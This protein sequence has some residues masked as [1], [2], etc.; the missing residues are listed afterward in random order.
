MVTRILDTELVNG[1]I[2]IE[3]VN[4]FH[5]HDYIYFWDGKFLSIFSR[6]VFFYSF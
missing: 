6:D 2:L 1:F 3:L 4:G 5:F